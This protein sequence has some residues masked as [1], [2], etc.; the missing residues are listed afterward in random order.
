[1]VV[2]DDMIMFRRGSHHFHSIGVLVLFLLLVGYRGL[3]FQPTLNHVQHTR[4]TIYFP[5][6]KSGF[7]SSPMKHEA[8]GTRSETTKTALTEDISN[9]I[10]VSTWIHDSGMLLSSDGPEFGRL[11]TGILGLVL[12]A[13]VGAF[14]FANV[15]YTP[16]ILEGAKDLRRSER[17]AEIRKLL[18][19]VQSHEK[20]GKDLTELRV[21]LET[22]LG[23][24]LED[25]VRAVL[26]PGSDANDALFTAADMELATML[27][28]II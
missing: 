12:V 25:Y 26:E 7:G 6:K 13:S 24:T 11:V 17:E 10:A 8:R 15:V 21:P 4:K 5:D 22:A 9:E 2:A 16:E 14:V 23:K 1:L 27:K 20:G 18:K 3:A 19:A 28:Q